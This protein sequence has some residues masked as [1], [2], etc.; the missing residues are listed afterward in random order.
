MENREVGANCG[1]RTTYIKN[2]DEVKL[3]NAQDSAYVVEVKCRSLA[4]GIA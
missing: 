1:V 3:F 2:A 4:D